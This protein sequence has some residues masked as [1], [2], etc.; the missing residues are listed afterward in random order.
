MTHYQNA[1]YACI[2][3]I[4]PWMTPHIQKELKAQ[5]RAYTTGDISHYKELC[6]KVSLL[7]S[8]A[9]ENYYLS[10]SKDL[11]VSQ[12]EKLY[13]TIYGFATINDSPNC[14][15]PA[16]IIENLVEQLQQAFIKPW[17]D[18]CHTDPPDV[19]TVSHLLK[20]VPPPLPSV[21]QAKSTLK[22][23]NPKKATGA[24]GIPAWLLKRFNE[25]VHNII[26]ASI[27][28]CKYPKPYKHA[29]IC[30]VPKVNPPKDI[31]NDFQQISVLPQLAKVLE[32]LQLSLHSP[33]LTPRHNQHAFTQNR[34]TVSALA[35]I[36]QN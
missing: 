5:Q 27:V 7:I 32:K 21:G 6:D 20:D 19:Q 8:K 34:S 4:K 11:L 28:Q 30:P 25:I 35:C 3:R 1:L 23:L 24:D 17:L 15:P 10:N 22:H 18:V 31:N 13:K 2:R 16:E 33:D 36:S 12:P 29:L 14:I 9:K 26:C